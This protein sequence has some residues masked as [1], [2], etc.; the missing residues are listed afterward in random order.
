MRTFAASQKDKME[1]RY[2]SDTALPNVDGK[3]KAGAKEILS[4]RGGKKAA[5]HATA[6]LWEA[7]NKFSGGWL[8]TAKVNAPLRVLE[9]LETAGLVEKAEDIDLNKIQSSEDYLGFESRGH[10]WRYRLTDFGKKVASEV[11]AS[12]K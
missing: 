2:S 3:T 7:A 5:S 6:N 4:S 8:T 12:R 1:S 11:A 9:A 10:A